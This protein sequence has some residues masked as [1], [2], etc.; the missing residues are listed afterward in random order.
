MLYDTLEA[1]S[2]PNFIKFVGLVK[3]NN[4]IVWP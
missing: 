2:D 4:S 3:N 1:I